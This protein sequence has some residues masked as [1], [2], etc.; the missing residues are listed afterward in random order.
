MESHPPQSIT[1]PS[2]KTIALP[3]MKPPYNLLLLLALIVPT[4]SVS[5]AEKAEKEFKLDRELRVPAGPHEVVSQTRIIYWPDRPPLPE[6]LAKPDTEYRPFFHVHRP[7]AK[8]PHPG[9]LL[10]HGGGFGAGHPDQFH[11]KLPLAPWLASHGYSVFSLGYTLRNR[12]TRRVAAIDLRQ[13][14]RF[15]RKNA[16]RFHVD[17]DRLGAWGFSA[18]G[19]TMGQMLKMPE[20]STIRESYSTDDKQK[21]WGEHP[22]DGGPLADSGISTRLQVMVFSSGHEVRSN[23][24][25]KKIL[26]FGDRVPDAIFMYQAPREKPQSEGR[27]AA[28]HP[29]R[30]AYEKAGAVVDGYGVPRG[31]HCPKLHLTVNRDGQEVQVW[32][33]LFDFLETHL[34]KSDK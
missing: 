10:I 19:M 1:K 27:L 9:L 7:A 34:K 13:A 21:L 11:T 6:V 2:D 31:K 12:T 16:D 15:I 14:I 23:E 26:A 5:A 33:A 3:N 20:N 24:A 4:Y 22:T 25:A 28:D 8:G 18:G 30:V 17:P 29:M 32:Q